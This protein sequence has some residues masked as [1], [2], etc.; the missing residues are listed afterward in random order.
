MPT[1]DFVEIGE[2]AWRLSL[3]PR[4]GINVYLLGSVLVDA[5]GRMQAKRVLAA[6]AGRPV[7]AHAITHAHYDHQGGSHA[8]C[9]R[10]GIP[11][12][13]GAGDREAMETG[14]LELL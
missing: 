7:V 6:L 10:L 9:A 1:N 11:L 12:W 13:C 2:D 5:G 4:D 8:I 3:V 14:A